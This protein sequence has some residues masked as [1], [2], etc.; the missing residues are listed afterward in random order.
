MK[1][2]WT[3]AGGVLPLDTGGRIRS[4][5]TLKELARRH[6]ITLHVFYEQF[7]GDEHA[8]LG[9]GD[10]CVRAHDRFDRFDTL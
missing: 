5:Q 4:F 2:L 10:G 9:S 8:S 6:E 3:K 1:I 7:A